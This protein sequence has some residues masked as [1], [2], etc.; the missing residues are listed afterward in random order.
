MLTFDTSTL[1][2]PYDAGINSDCQKSALSM[3]DCFFELHSLLPVK[4]PIQ[5]QLATTSILHPNFFATGLMFFTA[6][7]AKDVSG[8]LEKAK[9]LDFRC[10]NASP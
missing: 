6:V 1:L 2:R 10:R 3:I 9:L 7:M 8:S 5:K 4:F